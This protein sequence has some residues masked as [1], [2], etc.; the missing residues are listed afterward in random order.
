MESIYYL[1]SQSP[2]R[3]TLLKL[4][5]ND[6]NV[7]VPK[8]DE[9][10]LENESPINYVRRMSVGKSEA[11]AAQFVDHFKPGSIFITADTIVYKGAKIFGKPKSR[12]DGRAILRELSDDVHKV[13]TDVTIAHCVE[14]GPSNPL[15]SRESF[16]VSTDVY[17]RKLSDEIINSYLSTD[18]PWDKAGA[19]AV[20][21]KGGCFIK[22]IDGSYHNVVGLPIAELSERLGS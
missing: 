10:V 2:R 3:R 1:G 4:I 9:E 21:G 6:F 20:Q 19:Y 22:K 18:E 17:F 13:I 14:G 12:E 8:F 5:L 7:I 11:I 16:S 15:V